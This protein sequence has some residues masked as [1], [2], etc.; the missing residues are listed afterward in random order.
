MS[1]VDTNPDRTIEDAYREL[2]IER[3]LRD[4]SAIPFVR[5]ILFPFKAPWLRDPQDEKS[6]M[7]HQMEYTTAD[8]A[9]YAYPRLMVD[10]TGQLRDY[11]D[12]AFDEALRRKDFIR[13]NTPEE[14]DWF[15]KLYKQYWNQIGY[16]PRDAMMQDKT[17]EPLADP[18]A[19]YRMRHS[20]AEE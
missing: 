19:M 18:L 17:S 1:Q 13:F 20:G 2:G 8:N 10:E 15:T 14:A 16:D 9:A 6:I 4:N 3:I 7:T 11:G 12:Q 5:R